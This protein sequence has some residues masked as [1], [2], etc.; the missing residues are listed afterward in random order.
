MKNF[1]LT[2]S[3]L[4]FVGKDL[5]RPECVLATAA[6]DLYVSDNRAGVMQIRP[7][8]SQSLIGGAHLAEQGLQPNGIAL[9]RDGSFLIANLGRQSGGVWRLH[10]NGQVEPFLLEVDGVTLPRTNFV[11]LDDQD[12]VWVCVS[13]VHWPDYEF[14]RDRADGFIALVDRRGARIAGTGIVWTNECRIDPSGQYMYFNETFASRVSRFRL[15]PDGSL[16]NKEIVAE[17]GPGNFSDGLTFDQEGGAWITCVVSNRVI[18][19]DRDGSLAVVLEDFEPDHLAR[20]IAAVEA[21]TLTRPLVHENHHR[22][23]ANVSSLAF[24]GPD[25]RTAYLG[26]VLGNRLISFRSPVAGARVAH[27]EVG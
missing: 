4:T 24:G 2:L 26:S 10:R 27:W 13:T 1:H 14:S 11:Y 20:A 18:R 12:R 9:M 6:G 5:S 17:L 3:D 25:R 16:S 19:V 7:D 15:A 23:L 21:G 8:G 22:T